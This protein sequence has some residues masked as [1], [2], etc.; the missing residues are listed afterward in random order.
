M[1][2]RRVETRVSSID[3]DEKPPIASCENVEANLFFSISELD[4]KWAKNREK[5]HVYD[6]K[7]RLK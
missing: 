4:M 5:R 1:T 7:S 2:Y 6:K 3:S